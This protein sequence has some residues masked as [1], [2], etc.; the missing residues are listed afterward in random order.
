MKFNILL[1]ATAI[2][3]LFS[4]CKKDSKEPES[5]GK[6]STIEVFE[7]NFIV[8]IV[9]KVSAM[10]DF[11]AYYTEDGSSNYDGSKAVWSGIDA[12]DK[13]QTIKLILPH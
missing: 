13:F 7:P 2:L 3:F 11:A 4:A 6:S 9:A 8:Q 5:K 10:D 12:T 1:V